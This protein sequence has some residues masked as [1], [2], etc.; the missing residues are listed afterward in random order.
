MIPSDVAVGQPGGR[1]KVESQGLSTTTT[2]VYQDITC[3]SYACFEIVPP[4]AGFFE[5]HL[6]VPPPAGNVVAAGTL[7]RPVD[8]P[9]NL[10]SVSPRILFSPPARVYLHSFESFWFSAFREVE[11]PL[12]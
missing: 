5:T 3:L 6:I 8:R 10:I 4:S 7:F 9:A 12:L 1:W 2:R 11:V